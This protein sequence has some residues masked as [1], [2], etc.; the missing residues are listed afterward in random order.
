MHARPRDGHSDTRSLQGSSETAPLQLRPGE[1]IA[2]RYWLGEQ[3]GIGGNA[4]VYAATD[5]VLGDEV[6]LKFPRSVPRDQR[7]SARFARE[8]RMGRRISHRNACRIYDAGM[9]LVETT[10]RFE[11]V[12]PFVVMELVTGESVR[13]RLRRLG[14]LHG[15]E[16][17]RLGYQIADGLAAI[18]QAGLIHGDLKGA[19]IVLTGDD[20]ERAV[21]IDFGLTGEVHRVT[22]RDAASGSNRSGGERDAEPP[23]HRFVG[24]P[25]YMSPEQ[26]LGQRR[27]TESDVYALG[28]VLYEMA[29][30]SVP[31]ASESFAEMIARKRM[32][33]P[34]PDARQIRPDLPPRVHQVIRRCLA[35]HPPERYR[36]A[37]E[38]V[39]ALAGLT[40]RARTAREL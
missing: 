11:L 35:D 19:N 7:V 30:G 21:I 16:V 37:S 34:F 24:T 32:L 23:P 13:A 15:T 29:T 8:A 26:L 38:V 33:E 22:P 20:Q 14:W 28:T 1:L 17:T 18:H 10:D 2:R 25:A 3:V 36:D 12:L 39:E 4:Q 31:Y 6:A 5:Q 40:P 9:D 27:S